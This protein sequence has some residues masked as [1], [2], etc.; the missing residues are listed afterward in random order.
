MAIGNSFNLFGYS[1]VPHTAITIMCI[2]RVVLWQSSALPS[3][4]WITAVRLLT[5]TLNTCKPGSEDRKF[6]LALVD[7]A[8]SLQV[9]SPYLMALCEEVAQWDDS[10]S[11]LTHINSKSPSLRFAVWS[12]INRMTTHTPQQVEFLAKCV[13]DWE[14][15][16]S[17]WEAGGDQNKSGAHASEMHSRKRKR[18]EEVQVKD[19]DKE[20]LEFEVTPERWEDLCRDVPR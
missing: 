6:A 2:C 13:R 5:T 18:D 16:T 15:E 3:N 14:S 19:H 9:D 4:I 8:L 7:E 10:G 20:D 1:A 12:T 11:F 17:A